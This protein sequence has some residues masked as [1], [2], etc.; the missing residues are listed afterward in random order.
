[1]AYSRSSCAE[2]QLV[3]QRTQ[4]TLGTVD[5][6]GLN[7][8][9]QEIL[10]NVINLVLVVAEDDDRRWC[11]LQTLEE[12]HH[13]GL[14]LDVLDLLDDVHVGG[15]RTTDIDQD[16]VHKR[17]L[18]EILDLARHSRREQERV[19]LIFEVRHDTA[20]IV[21]EAHVDHAVRF[22]H[23]E[24]LAVIGVQPAPLQHV[25]QAAW[26][27]DDY[28]HALVQ[29]LI[30]VG[31]ADAAY[32]QERSQLGVLAGLVQLVA[33]RHASLVRLSSKLAGGA[34]DEAY[35]ALTP[36]EGELRLHLQRL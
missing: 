8:L 25:H 32:A 27:R 6:N 35:W 23:A 12:V 22:V 16:G 24:V 14:G 36:H 34:D 11:L 26:S 19:A 4:L 18:C 10:L 20:H 28:V 7:T 33:H 30:L 2:C 3:I 13:L 29:H 31:H 15:T 21:L 9:E 1:M 5:R 17:L